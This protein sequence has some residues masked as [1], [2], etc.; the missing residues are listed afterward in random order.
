MK[1]RQLIVFIQKIQKLLPLFLLTILI[2][3]SQDWLLQWTVRSPDLPPNVEIGATFI[4][5]NADRLKLDWQKAY[6]QM[7]DDLAIRHIRL[8]VYWDQIEPEPGV[9]DWE[10][11]DWQMQ[12]AADA[13]AK[14]LLAIGHRVPRY[15]ECY[16]PA[17]TEGLNDAAF[18]NALFQM[19]DSVVDH[20]KDHAGLEAWQVENEPYANV[21]GRTWGLNC[22][23]ILS[24]LPEEIKFV[25]SVDQSKHPI[26]VTY[27]DT[28]WVVEQQRATLKLPSD[29]VGITMFEKL[30][31]KSP[32]FNG[33]VEP[34]RQLGLLAPLSL[35]YQNVLAKR[36]GKPLWVVELQAEPWGPN[37]P[38]DNTET[39]AYK[40][41]N[42]EMLQTIWNRATSAG[43]SRIYLWGVE[44]WIAEKERGNSL[45]WNA[46]K[47]LAAQNCK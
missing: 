40:T 30:F 17:W 26:V 29:I 5:I 24:Y 46:G 39:E 3:F 9:F 7:I 34:Y 12:V 44:W 10:A 43:I 20:Y 28:P 21:M 32:I 42:P 35:T 38:Y 15:P 19:L 6:R 4:R 36:Q 23:E 31:F 45:M 2:V 41:M 22:R 1:Y 37:G 27:T 16:A 47:G 11:L 18:K 13:D 8:P 25:R 14:I 33:Y